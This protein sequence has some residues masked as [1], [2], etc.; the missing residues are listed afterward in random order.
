MHT[1][2]YISSFYIHWF[3]VHLFFDEFT[4]QH[5]IFIKYN[6]ISNEPCFIFK[7]TGILQCLVQ[8]KST[9]TKTI[10]NG[11]IT[12]SVGSKAFRWFTFDFNARST[13][14]LVFLCTAMITC[15]MS[16]CP[17]ILLPPGELQHLQFGWDA[18]CCWWN[19]PCQLWPVQF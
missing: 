4:H 12:S 9:S 7:W 6:E 10:H 1:Y 5:I 8:K 16:C 11:T 3:H 14:C 13:H 18:V 17:M 2:I 19:N 15:I